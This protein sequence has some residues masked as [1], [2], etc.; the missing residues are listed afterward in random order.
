M[1]N[2]DAPDLQ[3]FVGALSRWAAVGAMLAV[4]VMMAHILLEVTLRFV[5]NSTIPG[6]HD[7]VSAYYMIF[8]VFLPLALV[9]IDEGHVKVEIFTDFLSE[10]AKRILDGLVLI[11]SSV[12]TGVFCYASSIK[13]LHMTERG[14]I[15][16]GLV[17]VTVW[18][19]RWAL[20]LGLGLLTLV[21]VL[22][23]LAKLFEPN[24][25]RIST[26]EPSASRG[27]DLE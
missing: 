23:G 16:D 13:A 1:N 9:Q 26:L 15:W 8:I 5:N 10:K 11:V 20:P 3:T 21:F 25:N 18:P 2:R 22:Q 14:E 12:F 4:Y 19:A 7:I 6:T 24:R 27:A 17:E